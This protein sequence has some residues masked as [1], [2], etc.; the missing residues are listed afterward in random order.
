VN[1]KIVSIV[2]SI[3]FL[4]LTACDEIVLG[5][6]FDQ[7]ESAAGIHYK[8]EAGGH[9][10]NRIPTLTKD[11]SILKFQAKFDSSAI[12]T[13]VKPNNQA[14]INKLYGMA[15]CDSNHHQ[16]SARFGWRWYK[17]NLEI[18]A[19]AYKGGKWDYRLIGTASFDVYHQYEISFE[20]NK[21]VFKFDNLTAEMPRQCEGTASGYKLFPYF[22]GDETA[23]H[24]VSIWIKE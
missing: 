7:E 14:D 9:D 15:D 4:S 21:Y 16:N 12:Y 1:R 10:S 6:K 17:N 3:L 20:K 5:P 8:I 13:S 2:S 18:L 24:D 22:G 11:V 19:Y 23:P